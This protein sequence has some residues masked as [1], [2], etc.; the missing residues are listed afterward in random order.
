MSA[1]IIVFIICYGMIYIAHPQDR[2]LLILALIGVVGA[3]ILIYW[4]VYVKD[5]E[6]GESFRYTRIRI[7]FDPFNE[8][9][10]NSYQVREGLYGIATGG[11]FG[12]GL[13]NSILKQGF[14]R[15]HITI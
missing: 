13:G 12:R 6:I 3:A 15:N 2:K 1:A 5:Y 7:W 9:Y 14:C 10:P 8:E 4:I 11:L